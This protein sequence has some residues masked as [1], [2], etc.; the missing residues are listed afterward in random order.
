MPDELLL[1][2]TIIHKG[3]YPLY[4]VAVRFSELARGKAF[5][6]GGALRSSS[7][8]KHGAGTCCDDGHPTAASW[9]G[10]RIQHLLYRSKWDVDSVLEN[11]VGWRRRGEGDQG[12]ARNAGTPSRSVGQFPTSTRWKYRLGRAGSPGRGTEVVGIGSRSEPPPALRCAG[13]AGTPTDIFGHLRL[14]PPSLPASE[15]PLRIGGFYARTISGPRSVPPKQ[16]LSASIRHP[17][18]TA[19]DG[20]LPWRLIS[21]YHSPPNSPRSWPIAW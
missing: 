7:C 16:L 1:V 19:A 15:L 2:P 5:D 3:Q 21:P 6:I 20:P 14:F 12:D 8:W 13:S 10:P 11:A 17:L 4:D 18:G 9:Q